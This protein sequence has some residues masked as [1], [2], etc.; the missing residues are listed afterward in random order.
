MHKKHKLYLILLAFLAVLSFIMF[1]LEDIHDAFFYIGG[2]ALI[3]WLILAFYMIGQTIYQD[4]QI[5]KN[6]KVYEKDLDQM[7]AF[8]KKGLQKYWIYSITSACHLQLATCYLMKNDI[9]HAKEE[10][11]FSKSIHK[12]SYYPNFIIAIL[13]DNMELA[14]AYYKKIKAY[15]FPFEDQ[16]T[17][18]TKMMKMIKTKVFDEELYQNSQYPCV[19][20][21]CL[22]YKNE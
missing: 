13:E 10:L 9:Q 20:E 15:N 4:K 1:F 5:E 16:A 12:A 7:I 2:A 19:K 22:K 14:K 11:A 8:C 18:A 21:Y 3:L 6:F 17:M